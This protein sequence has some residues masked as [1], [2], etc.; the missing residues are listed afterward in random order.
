MPPLAE[1]SSPPPRAPPAIDVRESRRPM[2]GSQEKDAHGKS[3][4][5][6]S[7]KWAMASA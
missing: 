3:P 6:R 2:T 7:D 4:R 5:R 1:R